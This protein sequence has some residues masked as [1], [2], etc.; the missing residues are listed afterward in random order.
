MFGLRKSR[1][2]VLSAL[3]FFPKQ[4]LYQGSNLSRSRR[5][6]ASKNKVRDSRIYCPLARAG[7]W[8]YPEKFALRFFVVVSIVHCAQPQVQFAYPGNK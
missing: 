1:G 4:D 6:G 5:P 2:Q 3:N 8:K 7:T